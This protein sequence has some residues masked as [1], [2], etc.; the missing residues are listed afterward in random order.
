[1]HF[2]LAPRIALPS[3]NHEGVQIVTSYTLITSEAARL[4]KLHF[5][6]AHGR[7]VEFV[8]GIE[9]SPTMMVVSSANGFPTDPDISY[10]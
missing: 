4:A 5:R 7:L 3:S 1:L 9:S 8:D 6:D 10:H 2:F